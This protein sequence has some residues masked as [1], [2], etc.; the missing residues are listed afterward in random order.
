MELVKSYCLIVKPRIIFGNLITAIAGFFLGSK[1][2]FDFPLFAAVLAGLSFIIAS[3][4][5][6]NNYIDREA[7]KKMPR[8]Q[9]RALAKGLIP[10]QSALFYALLL[11]IFGILYLGFYVNFLTLGL[12]L[13]GF[14]VYVLLYSLSKYHTIHA[15]LIGSISGALPPVIGYTA[16]SQ[17]LDL[18]ALLLFTLLVLWQMP[19]FFAIAIYRLEDYA[20]ASIPV[21]PLIAG[22][23][24]TKIQMLLYIIGFMIA[25]SLFFF[26]HYAGYVYL[27]VSLFLG[28]A[29]LKISIEGFKTKNDPLWARKMFLFSLIVIISSCLT[30]SFN[31]P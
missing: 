23:Q 1:D 9:Q 10:T 12:A 26:L 29:W 27:I 2:A 30:L 14:F 22:I 6:F 11:L 4:C 16:V 20:A 15:T 8:T 3:A 19:H 13:I 21:L 7:D 24:K 18:V 17:Q 31:A 28:L 5:V 25:S